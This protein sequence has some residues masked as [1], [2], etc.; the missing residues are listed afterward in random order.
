MSAG[1]HQ[2]EELHELDCD[3]Q[4]HEVAHAVEC[5]EGGVEERGGLARQVRY[6]PRH[7]PQHRRHHPRVHLVLRRHNTHHYSSLVHALKTT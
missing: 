6:Q 2:E 3:A 1:E 4:R 7:A 5:V